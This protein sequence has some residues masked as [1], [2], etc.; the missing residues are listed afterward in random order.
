MGPGGARQGRVGPH[1]YY[2]QCHKLRARLYL[3]S[4]TLQPHH[5]VSQCAIHYCTWCPTLS[6]PTTRY[7]SV[8]YTTVP[9]VQHS[10]APPAGV[11]VCNTLL[12]LVSNTPAP[13]AGVPVYNTLLYLVSNTLQPHHQ[14]SQLRHRCRAQGHC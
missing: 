5:Q 8:Q 9:G 14:V 1:S 7:H 10:P 13:P 3:V 11:T 4:N 12:Y 2:F 6:S